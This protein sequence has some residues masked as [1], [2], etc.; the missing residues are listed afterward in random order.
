MSV[1]VSSI[2]CGAQLWRIVGETC[3]DARSPESS[4][5]RHGVYGTVNKILAQLT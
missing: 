5:T 1:C 4:K 2:E 3:P